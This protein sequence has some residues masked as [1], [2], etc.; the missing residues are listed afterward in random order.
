LDAWLFVSHAH[1]DLRAV[2]RVRDELERRHANP[3]LFFLMCLQQDEEIDSLIKR[4]ISARYFFILCDSDA[5][6]E[7][8]WVQKERA[9][10]KSLEGRKIYNLDLSWPWEEQ[11]HVIREALGAVTTFLNY[12]YS[13]RERVRPYIDLLI[14][15]DFACAPG[16]GLE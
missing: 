10:V 12:L 6:R 13:D 4:E 5:A 11:Q 3:L 15:N 9:F 16:A 7:S 8:K 1:Q 2:R 14:R